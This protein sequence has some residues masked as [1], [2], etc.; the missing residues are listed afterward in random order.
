[1]R[2]HLSQ[3][4][5]SVQYYVLWI[6]LLELIIWGNQPWLVHDPWYAPLMQPLTSRQHSSFPQ[7]QGASWARWTQKSGTPGRHLPICILTEHYIV[8]SASFCGS[9]R[10]VRNFPSAHVC[11][12][13]R[14]QTLAQVTR[15]IDNTIRGNVSKITSTESIDQ[16]Q[17]IWLEVKASH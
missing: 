5:Y 10:R 1:M 16:S 15:P 14:F 2:K 13:S 11:P 9:Y 17:D 6:N 7:T 3:K 4:L 12:S 8:R